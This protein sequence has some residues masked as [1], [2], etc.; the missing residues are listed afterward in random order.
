MLMS[1]LILETFH[2]NITFQKAAAAAA[3]PPV[4]KGRDWKFGPDDKGNEGGPGDDEEPG[5][6]E[7]ANDNKISEGRREEERGGCSDD[8]HGNEEEEKPSFKGSRP[9]TPAST[10]T[11]A[12]AANNEP[13]PPRLQITSSASSRSHP[14]A[15]KLYRPFDDLD[16]GLNSNSILFYVALEIAFLFLFRRLGYPLNLQRTR[17][18]LLFLPQLFFNPSGCCLLRFAAVAC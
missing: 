1:K 15:R 6:R 10:S 12:A 7:T 14:A 13:S 4:N 3:S 18:D 8:D 16:G 11:A 9:T 2:F 5:K 17:G